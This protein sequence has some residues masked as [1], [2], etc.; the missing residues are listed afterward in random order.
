MRATVELA[1]VSPGPERAYEAVLISAGVGN[2]LSYG[3]EVL[4]MA[5]RRFEGVCV[6]VDHPRLRDQGEPRS[7]RELVG[8]VE[9]VRWSPAQEAVLGRIRVVAGE[10]ADWFV[11][12]MDSW[13]EAR[14]L[15]FAVPRVG[16]SAVMDITVEGKEV[17]SVERVLSVDAVVEPARGGEFVRVANQE[18]EMVAQEVEELTTAVAKSVATSTS[19]G[20]PAA[21]SPVMVELATCSEAEIEGLRVALGEVLLEDRL[22]R[23]ELP[24]GL[25]VMLRDEYRGKAVA[26]PELDRRIERLQAAWARSVAGTG[27]MRDVGA[28]RHIALG[29]QE[30]DRLQAAVDRLVGLRPASE[31]QADVPP[32]TG[33]RELYVTCTGDYEFSGAFHPERVQ[34]ANVTTTT[35]SSLVKN[36]FNKVILDYFNNVDRWWEPI[37]VHE[38]FQSMKDLTLITLGGFVD[39][40]TVS[41]GAAYTELSWSDA[42]E[43][44]SFVKKG[45]Y[46]GVTLEMM[47]K[48]E[49]NKFRAIPRKLAIAGYRTLSGLVSALFTD[50]S[51][52][53]PYWPASQ[54]TYYVFD[55]QYSNLGSTALSASSWDACIQAMYKQ[56]EATSGERMG[57]RPSFLLVP[58]E[59][60]KTALTIM[61]SAGEPGTADNDANVRRAS[62]RV[63]AVPEWTDTNNWAAVADPRVW[64][65]VYIGYRYGRAPEVFIA[66]EET[67][68]SMFTND[69][70]RIKA[71]FVVAVGVCDVKPLYK[72][73]VT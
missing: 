20:Q 42:E 12:F 37:A 29:M 2:G 8:V 44:V 64:P 43:V 17:R 70:M 34:L 27:G 21:L 41:E 50:N 71:R 19:G 3:P 52:V 40:P 23:C 15:G 56:A 28:V 51:G 24:E 58:I 4:R 38:D 33:I 35:M 6:F 46:V 57:I 54:S 60:E 39:L 7:L 14:E 61:E 48:D 30:R 9:A 72:A 31:A 5:T 49:T 25:R 66:G 69:E 53:G 62:S 26:P 67:V 1:Q 13:L 11:G 22:R 63:I 73:N 18:E 32:L 10:D 68:G 45:G 59:L 55:A 36:A 16:L 65:G 47:D